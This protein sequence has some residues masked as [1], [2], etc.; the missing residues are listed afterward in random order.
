MVTDKDVRRIALALDGT[1]E[2][3]H[4]DRAAFKAARICATLAPDGRTAN[5]RLAPDEQEL[6]CLLA[7]DAFTPIP[8]AWSRRGWTT[9]KLAALDV[10]E[11]RHALQMA[12]HHAAAPKKRRRS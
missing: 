11:L 5:L 12:W 10:A 7:P 2:A 3:P 4:F 8:D 6:K 9:V 1:T